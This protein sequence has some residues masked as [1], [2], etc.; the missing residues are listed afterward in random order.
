MKIVSILLSIFSIIFV[1]GGALGIYYF[2]RGYRLNISEREIKRTGVLTVQS[3]PSNAQVYINGDSVGKT[4]RS[5]TL[6]VGSHRV[7]VQKDG[8]VEWNKEIEIME[9]KS[10]PIYP[11]LVLKELIPSNIWQSEATIENYWTN[12]DRDYFIFLL[13]DTLGQYSLWTYRINT[14]IWNLNP[15]PIQILS[16]ETNKIDLKISNNGLLAIMTVTENEEESAYI[17][18]L[19]NPT[20]LDNLAPIE[21]L[22][23]TE[24]KIHWSKDNRHIIMESS[25]EIV[26]LDTSNLN[27]ETLNTT[28]TL[29][30]KDPDTEYI[31]STDEEG[32]FYLLEKLHT[33][34][35]ETYIYALKQF[36]PDGTDPKYTIERAFFQK[37]RDFIQHYREN[38]DSYPE[39]TNSPQSTQTIGEIISFE[40]NQT[41]NGVYISTDTSTYWYDISEDRYRM[42]CSHPAQLISF[43]PDSRRLLFA[44]GDYIYIFTLEKDE[45]NHADQIGT[46]KVVGLRKDSVSNMHWLSN[47]THIRY[48]ENSTL[49]LTEKDGDNKANLIGVENILLH[50]IKTNREHLV[51]LESK[52]GTLF[53][54]QYKIK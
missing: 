36:Q 3:E 49:Y 29:V 53:I 40:V 37:N 43:S 11:F 8:Y 42:I 54:N 45:G 44:N 20:S 17:I 9:E 48:M 2:S 47:S 6:D 32:F 18:E 51:T 4:P 25:E 12:K 50:S 26:S 14:P 19:N 31:W 16:L 35:D 28:S 22:V 1:I 23:S 30:E 5:R 21:Q 41:T 52:E 33:E 34:E 24:H 15:N 13:L 10:T 27:N 39:F 38:G 7:S 46:E